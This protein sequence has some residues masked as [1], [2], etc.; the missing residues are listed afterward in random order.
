M[1]RIKEETKENK[2]IKF[3]KEFLERLKEKYPYLEMMDKYTNNHT[4][5]KFYCK[6]HD[7]YFNSTTANAL[8]N[9][10][11]C[12]V[13][14]SK[15]I[16]PKSFNNETYQERLSKINSSLVLTSEY[17]NATSTITYK[18]LKCGTNNQRARANSLLVGK[19]YC[20]V[21]D[22]SRRLV[23]GY[24]DI[25]VTHPQYLTYF[26]DINDAKTH[27]YGSSDKVKM[28]CPICN[29]SRILQINSLINKGFPCPKC[30]DGFSYPNKF[31]LGLLLQLKVD[32]DREVKFDWS[33]N[34]MYDFVIDKIIIEM[35]GG[36]HKGSGFNSAEE[37]KKTD[38]LKD[39]LAISNGYEII[40]IDC[41]K[42]KFEY[43]KSNLL[44]SKL[45]TILNFDIVNWEELEKSLINTN[46]VK[47]VAD[48]FNENVY[49][50]NI[51]D[52]SDLVG[53]PSTTFCTLLKKSSKL[54]FTNYNPKDSLS[55]KYTVNKNS[56][57]KGIICL[58]TGKIYESAF[59]AEKEFGFNKDSIGRV[60]RGERLTIN[61]LRFDFIET[62]EE[63]QSK[64]KRMEFSKSKP[65]HSAKV[66]YC[67]ELD[68][69]FN[70]SKDASLYLGYGE[71][72]V[73]LAISRK[74]KIGN[75]YTFRYV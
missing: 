13:S 66:V 55:G 3:E 61:G 56:I 45:A 50:I 40:R 44:N 71:K 54:G 46:Y 58:D 62:T 29:H 53:L 72:R 35:D 48:I 67:E 57:T 51:K 5:N 23:S 37:A 34:K 63:I 15:R 69:T 20:F 68:M 17:K 38:D 1:A 16:Y 41:N 25:T 24:N 65:S 52:M 31:M 19:A 42:S 2:R 47:I 74:E 26:E 18:C 7:N 32:F 11:C 12:P 75:K 59:S 39:Y 30:G 73:S 14:R 36:F 6:E 28:K 49:K 10:Y 21:C 4:M 43:I 60:C 33:Q 70:S 9:R 22:G 27:T 8:S 64:K